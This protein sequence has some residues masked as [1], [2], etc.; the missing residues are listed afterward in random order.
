MLV[1]KVT[2]KQSKP[3]ISKWQNT[4]GN[5]ST[6]NKFVFKWIFSGKQNQA[7]WLDSDNYNHLPLAGNSGEHFQ[8]DIG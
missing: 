5:F 6:R 7:F 2:D 3:L 4:N 8:K 1:I